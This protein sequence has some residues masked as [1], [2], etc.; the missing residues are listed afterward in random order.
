[1]RKPAIIIAIDGQRVSPKKSLGY[2]K[3]RGFAHR[4]S[5][6]ESTKTT[7]AFTRVSKND[8]GRIINPLDD[9]G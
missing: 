1:M 3:N 2:E 8:S 6:R 7:G 9:F 4:L 5:C